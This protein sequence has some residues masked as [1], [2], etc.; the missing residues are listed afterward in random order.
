[1]KMDVL[2]SS[3][4]LVISYYSIWCHDAANYNVK[5]VINCAWSYITDWSLVMQLTACLR[6]IWGV[7][8]C[9]VTPWKY[10]RVLHLEGA[11][12]LHLQG[13]TVNHVRNQKKQAANSADFLSGLFFDPENRGDMLLRNIGKSPNYKGLQHNCWERNKCPEKKN[14]RLYFLEQI[15]L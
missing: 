2:Y 3:E 14:L 12:R 5:Q 1:M 11:Y 15:L 8:F 13:W 10:E 6:W 4:M 9:F 7:T